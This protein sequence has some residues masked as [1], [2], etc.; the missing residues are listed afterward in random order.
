MANYHLTHK[1][2]EDIT[3]IWGHTVNIWSEQQAE[4][5]YNLLINS[6]TRILENPLIGIK[7]EEVL[8]GLFGY[9]VKKHIVFY[10]VLSNQEILIIRILHES[11]DYK[12]HLLKS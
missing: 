1:A 6:F 9:K 5:Y 10:Q 4:K 8:L 2:V 11:M 3:N 12:R 7:Y